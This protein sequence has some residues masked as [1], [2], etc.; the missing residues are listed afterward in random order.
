MAAN[1]AAITIHGRRYPQ[2]ARPLRRVRQDLP[3]CVR[4]VPLG[5]VGRPGRLIERAVALCLPGG[6]EHP[7]LGEETLPAIFLGSPVILRFFI[8]LEG[9]KI[10]S[11]KIIP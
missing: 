4:A 9:D 3:E 6:V 8:E 5:V 1:L 11:L 10:A 7:A 2:S